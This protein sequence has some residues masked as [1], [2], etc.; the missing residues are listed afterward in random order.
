[1][2][3]ACVNMELASLEPHTITMR[4]IDASLPPTMLPLHH[5]QRPPVQLSP[6]DHG[7]LLDCINPKVATVQTERYGNRVVGK[8]HAGPC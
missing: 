5:L 3:R 4:V 7:V 8:A 6:L 1:M 2:C